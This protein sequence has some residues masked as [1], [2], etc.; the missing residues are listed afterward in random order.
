MKCSFLKG[1]VGNYVEI[2]FTSV[3]IILVALNVVSAKQA[4]TLNPSIAS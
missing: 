4:A 2:S 1:I 3:E